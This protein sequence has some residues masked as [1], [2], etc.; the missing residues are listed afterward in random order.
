[1]QSDPG[2]DGPSARR[3]ARRDPIDDVLLRVPARAVLRSDER[4][5]PVGTVGVDGTELDFRTARRIGAA[6]LDDRYTDLDRGGNGVARITVETVD[7]SGRTPW[8]DKGYPYVM[9]FTN[10]IP[11]VQRRRLAVEPMTCPRNA[12]RR[13]SLVTLEPGESHTAA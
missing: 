4:G 12:F 11:A 6:K 9:V 7:G 1:M 2:N 3:Q 10:D 8:V 13:G 5:I